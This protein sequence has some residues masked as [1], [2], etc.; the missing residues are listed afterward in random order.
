MQELAK[1]LILNNDHDGAFKAIVSLKK[2]EKSSIKFFG[3]NSLPRSLAIGIKQDKKI[4]K[5]PLDIKENAGKFD[6]GDV[7]LSNKLL[8]AVVDISNPFC[9][10]ILLSGSQNSSVVNS[11]IENAFV[12]GKP[13]D[14]SVLYEETSDNDIEKLIDKNLEDDA[15]TTYFDACAHCKYR[16][17]FYKEG[18]SMCYRKTPS[19]DESVV[20]QGEKSDTQILS[21]KEHK[22]NQNFEK[23]VIKEEKTSD[24]SLN[25][26]ENRE[27]ESRSFYDQVKPQIDALF[28]KYEPCD[29]LCNMIPY[30]KWVKI[31]Y[32]KDNN[33]YVLGLIFDE[34]GNVLYIC[35]GMPARNSNTPPDE[36]EEYAGFIPKNAQE[37]DGEGYFVVC[38][39]GETGRTLKIDLM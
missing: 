28:N 30:S 38:Q 34:S 24:D 39:D 18:G 32:D 9:P 5:I 8:C 2:K 31:I 7:D 29:D 37:P 33:F 25:H 19:H 11:N 22:P 35:Y 17:A 4:V 10:E 26:E 6:L 23:D 3:K 21:Q 1:T 16:E 36:L 15:K 20:K 12:Q 14:A 27:E 13:D